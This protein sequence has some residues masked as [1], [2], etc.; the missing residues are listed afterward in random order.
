MLPGLYGVYSAKLQQPGQAFWRVH[1]R[2]T[3][4]DRIKLSQSP[5]Y[6]GN[7]EIMALGWDDQSI[8]QERE[9]WKEDIMMEAIAGE[10]V[11]KRG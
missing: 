11:L 3:T 5:G 4:R 9:S 7:S 6:N 10:N 1:V 2:E 8:N